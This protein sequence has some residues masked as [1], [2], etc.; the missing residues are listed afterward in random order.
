VPFRAGKTMRD[1]YNDTIYG[2]MSQVES[3]QVQ[4]NSGAETVHDCAM[5]HNFFN[6]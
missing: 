4:D 5:S 2:T 1:G 3:C 6:Q